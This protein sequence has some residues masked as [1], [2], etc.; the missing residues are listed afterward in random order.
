MSAAAGT[1]YSVPVYTVTSGRTFILTDLIVNSNGREQVRIYDGASQA[2]PTASTLKM[3]VDAPF[4]VTDLKCGPKFDTGVSV[5]SVDSDHAI[6]T[7]AVWVGGYE[8]LR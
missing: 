3:V 8:I 2:T 7:Y 1:A 5:Q 4:V 6:G